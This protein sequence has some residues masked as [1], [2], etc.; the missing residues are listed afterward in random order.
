MVLL[1]RAHDCKAVWMRMKE[2]DEPV[3][4]PCSNKPGLDAL[5]S[6]LAASL[7]DISPE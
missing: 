7:P 1:R 2:A 5:D 3:L 4:L 6:C